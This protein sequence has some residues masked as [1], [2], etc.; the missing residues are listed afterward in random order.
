MQSTGPGRKIWKG[1]GVGTWKWDPERWGRNVRAG[2]NVAAAS[3]AEDEG[4]GEGAGSG[5][6][7]D[8]WEGREA[9]GEVGKGDGKGGKEK[10]RGR[11]EK[12]VKGKGGEEDNGPDRKKSA[13][14]LARERFAAEKHRSVSRQK[15][16][17]T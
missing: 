16:V 8:G 2:R 10:S 9:R 14:E 15:G 1:W 12:K 5:G 7:Q 6:G 13:I 4:E 11:S 3:A 17:R